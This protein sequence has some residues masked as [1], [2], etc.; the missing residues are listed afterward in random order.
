[1]IAIYARTSSDNERKVSIDSQVEKGKEFAAKLSL[2]YVTFIDRGIS[3]GRADRVEYEKMMESIDSAGITHLWFYDQSRAWR[4]AEQASLLWFGMKRRGIFLCLNDSI[5]EYNNM[6]DHILWHFNAAVDEAWRINTGKKIAASLQL[7]IPKGGKSGGAAPYGYRTSLNKKLEIYPEESKVVEKIFELSIKGKSTKY[8]AQYLNDRKLTNRN[9]NKWWNSSVYRALKRKAYFGLYI[10]NEG[11]ANEVSHFNPDIK[12]ISEET[13]NKAQENL[14]SNNFKRDTKSNPKAL[15]QG[16]LKCNICGRNLS[17]AYRGLKHHKENSYKR[18]STYYCSGKTNGNK[19]TGK[20]IKSS[21]IDSYVW[22]LFSTDGVIQSILLK[23]SESN[24][25]NSEIAL[26]EEEIKVLKD[27]KQKVN[28]KID[29]LIDQRLNSQVEENFSQYISDDRAASIVKKLQNEINHLS[30]E[31]EKLEREK[32]DKQ[33]LI[34]ST[35]S[36]RSDIVILTEGIPREEK[37]EYIWRYIKEIFVGFNNETKRFI[38][39]FNFHHSRESFAVTFKKNYTDIRPLFNQEG[40]LT[41]NENVLKYL[42]RARSMFVSPELN[43]EI[44]DYKPE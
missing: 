31:I 30:K 41:G 8:I 42:K 15:L 44:T 6:A 43:I 20:N 9:G 29:L 35:E 7:R 13:Y 33:F 38:L 23:A 16:V 32:N 12:I 4:E 39:L 26:I 11:K 36:L 25:I 37:R 2:P 21:F 5:L 10:V 3:G 34:S 40:T 1:M 28:A 22:K 18:Q 17:H 27:N 24:K 14:D 19:C